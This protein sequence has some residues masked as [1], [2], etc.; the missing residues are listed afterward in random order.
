Y[1][2]R[3][4]PSN[5]QENVKKK[6]MD[7]LQDGGPR[8]ALSFLRAIDGQLA[9]FE[10]THSDEIAGACIRKALEWDDPSLKDAALMPL[11]KQFSVLS[12]DKKESHIDCII[13]LLENDNLRIIGK[14]HYDLVNELLEEQQKRRILFELLLKLTRMPAEELNEE[15]RPLMEVLLDLQHVMKKSDT[16]NFLRNILRMLKRSDNAKQRRSGLEYLG[17][18]EKLYGLKDLVL[19]QAERATRADDKQITYFGKKILNSL[20][21]RRD[22]RKTK[23]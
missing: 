20:K 1:V 11:S 12:Q 19:E 16:E 14:K 21:K 18:I 10:R 13:N 17:Q 8:E 23:S 4:V 22:S 7:I 6:L 2:V 9:C 3:Y 5:K 15:I